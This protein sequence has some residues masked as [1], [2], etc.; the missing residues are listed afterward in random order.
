MDDC[1]EDMDGKSKL[2]CCSVS[3]L[4]VAV[5]T[6][7]IFSFA[8][9]EPT[10]YAITENWVSKNIGDEVLDGGLQFVGVFNEVHKYPATQVL[11][12]FSDTSDSI[13]LPLETRTQEG[14]EL[15]LHFAF[16]YEVIKEEIPKLYRLVAEN[17]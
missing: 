2:I 8:S 3:T 14:L 9:I 15:T 11:L 13:D 7:L 4:I 17:Y 12:E 10:E 6:C 1:F 5:T 16:S